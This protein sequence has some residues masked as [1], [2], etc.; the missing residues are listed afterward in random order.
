MQK[1][2]NKYTYLYVVQ[3]FYQ[4]WEDLTCS[5]SKVECLCDLLAYN[6]NAPNTAYR[7][8]HRRM[9]RDRSE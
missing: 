7:I 1:K 9:L 4:T 8:V 2:T 3:G 5:E 6:D